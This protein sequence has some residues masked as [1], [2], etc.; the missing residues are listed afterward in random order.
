[1]DGSLGKQCLK[2]YIKNARPVIETFLDSEI[3]NAALLGDIP[4]HLMESF[5]ASVVEGKGIRGFLVTL[6]YQLAN[7]TDY[8]DILNTSIFIEI[9]HS[10]ILAHDDFMD[11]DSLRRGLPT[12]H[13]QFAEIG[14]NIGIK[15][16][17]NHYG[18]A[19]AICLGDA[20]F[21]LSWQKL[22]ESKASPELL[23]KAS[24]LY[25]KYALRLVHGQVLDMTIPAT[26]NINEEDVL[27]VI[28]TKSGE[29]TALLPLHVGATL[30]GMQ[31]QQKLKAIENY[32]KCFGWAFQIQ[33]DTLGMFS[34][35]E[36]IG[37]PI[38][39]DLR[40]GKNTLYMLHLRKHGTSE[41]K[42]IQRQLLGNKS[43][44]KEDVYKM[45]EILQASGSY[46]YVIDMGWNYVEE[47]KQYISQIT[48][49]KELADIMESLLVFMMERAK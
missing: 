47:G 37:K 30:G 17:P 12:I 9:F 5:K 2:E 34:E 15:T 48:A 46:K 26:D 24:Q 11:N 6:G 3:Q 42:E 36:K 32:A 23:L 19:L 29:Y 44:T 10:G 4:R 20:S 13:K 45:R 28:W 16:D 38:T 41:Q 33:D 25:I 27:K 21:Y 31:D 43:I 35:E 49:N 18:E 1:M 7:G 8:N 39:S 22:L 40:E 14:K